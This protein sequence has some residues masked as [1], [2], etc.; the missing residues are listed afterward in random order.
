MTSSPH[1]STAHAHTHTTNAEWA[2]IYIIPQKDKQGVEDIYFFETPLE[3]FRF[4]TL[5]LQI[6]EKIVYCLFLICKFNVELIG[7]K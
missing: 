6:P 5:P 1:S 7:P 2:K 3:I 4:L